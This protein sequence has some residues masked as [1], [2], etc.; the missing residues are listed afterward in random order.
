MA[1]MSELL[2]E[3]QNMG[4]L[5]LDTEIRIRHKTIQV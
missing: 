4:W 1:A 2:N 3:K 5:T